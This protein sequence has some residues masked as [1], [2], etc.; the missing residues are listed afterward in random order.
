MNQVKIL[1]TFI[2]ILSLFTIIF[3][4][5]YLQFFSSKP[6]NFIS[7]NQEELIEKAKLY[8][9]NDKP[10]SALE[11]LSIA[12]KK[13][14]V[15][16]EIHYLM[17]RVYHLGKSFT[18]AEEYC[19][20]ALE[21][22]QDYPRTLELMTDIK[23]EQGLEYWQK[24]DKS[25]SLKNFLYVL[26]NSSDQEKIE[27][28]AELTGGKYKLKKLTQ[29]IFP[30][31]AP[32]FSRDG[33]RIIFFSDTSYLSEDFGWGKN[34]KR[35]SQIF[36]IDVS[37]SRRICL[38]Q[39]DSSVQFPDISSDGK[40]IIYEKEN[41]N[42][43]TQT[44]IFNYDR[45]LYIKRLDNTEEVRLTENRWYDGQASFSP[46]DKKIV[47]V[48]GFSIKLM[49]LKTK[50]I[51][52][53]DEPEGIIIKWEKP[54]NQYYPSFSPDGKEILFQA[55]FQ[56][57]KIYLID[58]DGKNLR[59]LSRIEDEDYYPSFSPDGKKIVFVSKKTRAEELYLMD[60]DG[61]NQIRLTFD[62]M[63]KK[64][65]RF[66]PDGK[67]IAYVAKESEKPDPYF[68]IY[69]LYLKEIIPKDRLLTRIENM[70]EED[71]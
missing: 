35:K 33:K 68:E 62:K 34:I 7:L 51:T 24:R 13:N 59:D 64:H 52:N 8:I 3:F 40:K 56:K 49:D 10:D 61:K 39:G 16:P 29:D 22:E 67:Q 58:S 27:K 5:V 28:I 41:P 53:L 36:Q 6:D 19:L 71:N 38:T 23:F 26:R 18:L 63:D 45:D 54:V 17:A 14:P 57:R 50:E 2:L 25:Q 55:G 42:P 11:A 4:L 32:R 30:D 21:L 37:G 9:E 69:I 70:L 20:K 1:T 48:S 12:L 43:E 66:S 60:R 65:P 46:D 44:L 31:Y 15:D 47:Y